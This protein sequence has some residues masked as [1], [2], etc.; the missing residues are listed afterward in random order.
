MFTC[1]LPVLQRPPLPMFKHIKTDTTVS[2]DSAVI[3]VQYLAPEKPH[4]TWY[5]DGFPIPGESECARTVNSSSSSSSSSCRRRRCCYY[6][7]YYYSA[8]SSEC[9]PITP[10]YLLTNSLTHSLTYLL[11]VLDSPVIQ[12]R[13]TKFNVLVHKTEL[14]RPPRTGHA[15]PLPTS[16][17][18]C[19]PHEP[20]HLQFKRSPPE[21]DRSN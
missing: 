19:L 3:T 16:Y 1:C 14:H 18:T 11:T 6:Y 4:A 8:K 15:E 9:S 21:R 7:Y 13:N 17:S 20:V 2:T 12:A 10:Y 5:V